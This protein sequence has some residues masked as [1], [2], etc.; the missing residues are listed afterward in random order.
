[1]P[2][3]TGSPAGPS[4]ITEDANGNLY[5]TY[6]YSNSDDGSGSVYR[7]VT[8][9]FQPGDFNGDAKVDA[10]DL[11]VWQSGF[12]TQSGATR[13][14]GDADGDGDVDGADYLVLQRNL[15]WSALNAATAASAAV[16]EPAAVSFTFVA[17][18]AAAWRRGRR[19]ERL[20]LADN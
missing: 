20:L 18:T 17:L 19:F 11:A 1:M 8:D 2:W 15:G 13:A 6:L 7:I 14:T 3:N 16:P 5:V 9:A 12:G 4:S 10:G